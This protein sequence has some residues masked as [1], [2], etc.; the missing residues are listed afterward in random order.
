M[1]ISSSSGGGGSDG[2][3]E[4]GGGDT[5][6]GEDASV[7]NPIHPQAHSPELTTEPST[8]SRA[9]AQQDGETGS[10]W[11]K[12]WPFSTW[13]SKVDEKRQPGMTNTEAEAVPKPEKKDKQTMT[14]PTPCD[15]PVA[16]PS[17]NPDSGILP[18][19]ASAASADSPPCESHPPPASAPV[20]TL[21][22]L[23][24]PENPTT[25]RRPKFPVHGQ[26]RWVPSTTKLSFETLWW[27]YRMSVNPFPYSIT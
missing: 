27:G 24:S 4:Q 20:S 19:Y 17:S 5:G 6:G 11:M 26:R 15:P 9:Y 10:S 8:S 1:R 21:V 16:G 25:R 22:P 23:I 7:Q 13:N 2:G 14:E 3:V 18:S 12:V